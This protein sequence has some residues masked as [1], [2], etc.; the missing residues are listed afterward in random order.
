M[1]VKED[2]GA[3]CIIPAPG[4]RLFW[5]DVMKGFSILWIVIFHFFGAYDPG[6]YPWPVGLSTLFPFAREH[7][8]GSILGYVGCMLEGLVAGFFQRGPQAVGV[9]I[10]LSGFGLTYS[11]TKKGHPEGG[12]NVWYRRR[13]VRLFP[14][15]WVAHLIALFAPLAHRSDPADWRLLMSLVGNRIYPAE[16]LFYY[17]VPAWWFFGL[18]IQLYLVFPALFRLLQRMGP[19]WFFIVCV[20]FTAASR[21]LFFGIL[22]ASGNYTQGAFFGGRLWEFSAGM[23]L[24]YLYRQHPAAVEDGF[25]SKANLLLGFVLYMGGVYSYQPNFLCS[26]TDG[27][28]GMGLFIL[29]A[30]AT[31]WAACAMPGF[32]SVLTTVGVYS[33][34][35]YLI[36]QP[37]VI[38]FGHLLSAYSL[39][40]FV[41][42]AALV[43]LVITL[44]GM[45]IEKQV[46]RISGRILDRPKAAPASS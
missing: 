7:G 10:V 13:L 5:L 12:W 33:Y 3:T 27:L 29:M 37:F 26:F 11:L 20:V 42:C 6:R 38:T 19:V 32:G 21:Y 1:T 24:A 8:G 16:T 28:I 34:G 23:V 17:L 46:N 14:M 2:I 31:R 43:M 9:F 18:L 4:P 30:Q 45:F 25:F 36:H 15:Y 40:M 39:P 22:E 44:A 41:L 35:L